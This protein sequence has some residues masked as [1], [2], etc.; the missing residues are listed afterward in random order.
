M[1]QTIINPRKV[2]HCLPL[3]SRKS[4]FVIERIG[5]RSYL[6]PTCKRDEYFECL[7]IAVFFDACTGDSIEYNDHKL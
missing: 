2:A 3:L 4:T 7:S 6:I 5:L 1:I